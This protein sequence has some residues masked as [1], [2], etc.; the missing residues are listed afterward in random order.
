M[1][2]IKPPSV[3]EQPVPVVPEDGLRGLVAV[4]LDLD[5][6]VAL[7]LGRAGGSGALPFGRN[8]AV[9]LDRYLRARDRHKHGRSLGSGWV[10]P[11][12]SPPKVMFV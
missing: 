11:D 12:R 7:V 10:E 6:D 5:L 1:A 2:K 9:A 8:T 3:P 4:Y